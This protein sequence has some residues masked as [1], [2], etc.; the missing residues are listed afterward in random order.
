M[1]A[2][3]ASLDIFDEAGMENLRAK[4]EKLTGYLEFM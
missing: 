1:A 4:S 3:K 2:L